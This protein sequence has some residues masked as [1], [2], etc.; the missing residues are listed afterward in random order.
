MNNRWHAFVEENEAH[1]LV[2][3]L[4]QRNLIS[5]A[6]QH[7]SWLAAYKRQ[8]EDEIANLRTQLASAHEVLERVM[9][10]STRTPS[11][12]NDDPLNTLSHE[13]LEMIAELIYPA[14]PTKEAK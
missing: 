12:P 1:A 2:L 14:T 7:M 4:D 8:N 11:F 6:D 9:L 3:T 13:T 5:D 10:E